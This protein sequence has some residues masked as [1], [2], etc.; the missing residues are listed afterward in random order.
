MSKKRIIG[1]IKLI[2]SIS[3]L[4]VV[5]AQVGWADVVSALAQAKLGWLGLALAM[6][7]VGVFVRAARWRLLLPQPNEPAIRLRRLVQLYFASFFFNS[8]LPTG[9]GGDIIRITEVSRTV[10][11]STAASSVIADRAIGLVASGLLALMA[12]PWVGGNLSWLLALTTGIVAIGLPIGF[13]LLTRYRLTGTSLANHLPAIVSPIVNQ[14][15][16][17]TKALM[18]YPRRVLVRALVVS[19]AFALTNVLTYVW[20]GAALNIDLSLAYYILVSPVITLILLI[21]VSVNGLGTRDVT[22][23]ALFVPVGVAP[24][25]ALAMSLTY[26]AFNLITAIIGGVVYAFMGIAGATASGERAD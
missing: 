2:V 3:L 8:F 23:Q 5:F 18:A 15:L 22:Y 11:L 1:L 7:F 19:L 24:Q 4:V 9:I 20:I 12:L 6:Y 21:P 10:G 17:I 14:M 26:H 16:E 25:A 13:W